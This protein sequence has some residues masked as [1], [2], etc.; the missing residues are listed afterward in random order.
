[1]DIVERA[2]AIYNTW[3]N[4]P[5]PELPENGGIVMEMAMEITRLREQLAE[6]QAECIA[7]QNRMDE[8]VTSWKAEWLATEN[9]RQLLENQLMKSENGEI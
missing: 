4:P 3:N 6:T 8:Q 7:L 1:M 5:S 9:A 2:K